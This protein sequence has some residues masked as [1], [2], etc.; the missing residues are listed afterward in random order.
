MDLGLAGKVAI[1]T[2]S[3]RGIGRGN[4]PSARGRGCARSCSAL[5]ARDDL[6]EAVGAVAGPGRAIG[7]VADVTDPGG[8][9]AVVEAAVERFGGVDIVVNNVG[10]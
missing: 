8:A 7:V 1:V 4:R 9:T 10:G 5:A 2:G 3:S 6:D